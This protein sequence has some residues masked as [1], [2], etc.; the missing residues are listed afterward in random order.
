[1]IKYVYILCK[2]N[3]IY[4]YGVYQFLLFLH[5][6]IKVLLVVFL[7]KTSDISWHQLESFDSKQWY[8]I[9]GKD[10]FINWELIDVFYAKLYNGEYVHY[11]TQCFKKKSS[12]FYP[13]IQTWI[14]PKQTEKLT[15]SIKYK[16]LDNM[17]I[18]KLQYY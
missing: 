3:N 8:L 7:K 11:F 6:I 4:I 12:L 13:F 18:I 1:M 10:I 17:N 16:N 15:M 5:F 9:Q 2:R 14:K